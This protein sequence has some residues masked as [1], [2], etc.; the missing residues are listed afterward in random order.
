M[1]LRQFLAVIAV[2]AGVQLCFAAEEKLSTATGSGQDLTA[3]TFA[4]LHQTI[5]PGPGESKWLQLPWMNNFTL[6]RKKAAAESK[7]ILCYGGIGAGPTDV[8]SYC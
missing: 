2:L 6:V 8:L 5:K 1:I 3:E 7:P 4:K